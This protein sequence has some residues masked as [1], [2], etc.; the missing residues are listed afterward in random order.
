MIIS[1]K[2]EN[3]NYFF[4]KY[5]YYPNARTG[6]RE[7]LN[8]IK[9]SHKTITILLP[10]YIGWSPNEGSGI[11]DPIIDLKINHEFYHLDDQLKINEQDLKNKIT[12][13]EG[14]KVLLLVHYFGYVDP[15]YQKLCE[16][17]KKNNCFIVED[18]AHALFTSLVDQRC[19][20]YGDAIFYSLHKM[21]PM[22][23]GGMVKVFNTDLKIKE[24]CL[25]SKN[26]FN[27]N[28]T[29]IAQ[30]RKRN[31]RIIEETLTRTHIKNIEFLRPIEI[32]SQQTPQTY[33]I[34]IKNKDRTQLYFQM[35]EAG[36]GVV[37][38]YHTLIESL[39]NSRYTQE[40]KVSQTILNL[41]V[42][43]DIKE[44][45]LISMCKQL[46]VFLDE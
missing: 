27:Y 37:S 18:A 31:A 25:N 22:N 44:E 24:S 26:L 16:Y 41:P 20:L 40:N 34:I 2:P 13:T 39:R 46:E 19:G 43:Q 15:S 7:V 28:F 14:P 45:E 5:L 17:A 30:K 35:N 8:V 1:K 12:Q 6:M 21:L 42:H 33:P 11:Y 38:L 29:G 10:A 23:N 9:N 3:K 32:F 4:E 36:Y